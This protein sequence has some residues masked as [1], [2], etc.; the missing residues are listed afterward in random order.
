[1]GLFNSLIAKQFTQIISQEKE[2]KSLS[3]LSLSQYSVKA[4]C[5]EYTGAGEGSCAHSVSR[6][7]A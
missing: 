5:S 1:M 6:D 3:S 7:R 4:I 2:E